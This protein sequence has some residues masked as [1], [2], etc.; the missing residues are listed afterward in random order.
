ME[1]IFELL[2]QFVVEF[3]P[4]VFE[5]LIGTFGEILIQIFGEGLFEI[6]FRGLAE[7]SKRTKPRNPFLAAIGYLLWGSIIGGLSLLLFRQSLI[8]QKSFRIMS[9]VFTPILAGISMSAIG[10]LRK[11]RGQDLIRIDSFFYGYLFALGMGVVRYYFA[12]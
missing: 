11:K 10:A 12:N 3:F 5:I 8:H 7:A 9:L 4:V 1:I 6:G 2:I